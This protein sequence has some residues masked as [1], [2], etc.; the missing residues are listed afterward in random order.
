ME[1]SIDE[2]EV[3]QKSEERDQEDQENQEEREEK[4][5]EIETQQCQTLLVTESKNGRLP[6]RFVKC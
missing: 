1:C 5:S 4:A 2:M 3:E 6:K